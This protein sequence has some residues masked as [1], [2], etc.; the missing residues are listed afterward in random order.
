MSDL[1]ENRANVISIINMKG[2]VGKTTLTV[3]LAVNMSK[4]DK[5]VLVIDLD[6]QFN[7]T[8][9]LI[10]Y[11]INHDDQTSASS[12]DKTDEQKLT[13]MENSFKFYSDL[14]DK[15]QT[16]L[17][18]FN[19]RNINDKPELIT[20]ISSNLDLI[21]GDLLLSNTGA[22]EVMQQAATLSMYFDDNLINQ[23]YD[24]IFIDNAPTWS[25]VLTVGSLSVSDYYLV[26]TKLEFYSSLGID[27]LQQKIKSWKKS[28]KSLRIPT[29]VE[30]LGVA[31]MFS[32][33]NRTEKTIRSKLEH[34][35]PDLYFF[36]NELNNMPTAG[37]K[38]TIYDNVRT[39]SRYE[40]LINQ[41]DKLEN[42]IFSKIN[43]MEK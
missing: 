40:G 17:S 38:F 19:P 11:R 4:K 5:K 2:G 12:D 8:Q 24:F 26:P 43:T 28:Q 42:D 14:S 33:G 30:S 32:E 20:S 15:G 34:K 9:S 21:A 16:V 37:S 6:P 3:N 29:L 41:F 1:K 31:V 25:Q 23:K 27:L 10:E 7:A 22:T 39:N 13:K 35:F 18:L 36:K